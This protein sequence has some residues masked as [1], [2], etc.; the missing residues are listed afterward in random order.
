MDD[1]AGAVIVE[2]LRDV[3]GSIDSFGL[4]QEDLTT[5]GIV[6]N[7]SRFTFSVSNGVV[8]IFKIYDPECKIHSSGEYLTQVELI[9]PDCTSKLRKIMVGSK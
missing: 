6:S 1:H 8:S 5:V 2:Y 7:G 9:D 4:I 3:F